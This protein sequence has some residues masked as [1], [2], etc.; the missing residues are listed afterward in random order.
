MD[1]TEF[2]N[3]LEWIGQRIEK[4]TPK[5]AEY[6]RG[7]YQGIKFYYR[8]GRITVRDHYHLRKIAD[9][10]PAVIPITSPICAGIAMA[11]T[12]RGRQ[13]RPGC[14]TFPRNARKWQDKGAPPWS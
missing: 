4:S 10:T 5:E 2:G 13:I 9:M 11:V 7:Y 8:G 3:L 14:T 12:G 6:W 1:R